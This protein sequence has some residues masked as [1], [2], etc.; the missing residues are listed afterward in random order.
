[1]DPIAYRRTYSYRSRPFADLL[2]LLLFFR[3]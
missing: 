3:G 2:D 1:M